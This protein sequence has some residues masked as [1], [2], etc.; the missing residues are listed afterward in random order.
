MGS[1]TIS[2]PTRLTACSISDDVI[3]PSFFDSSS[4]TLSKKKNLITLRMKGWQLETFKESYSH[5]MNSGISLFKKVMMER[6]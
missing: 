3:S 5:K 4:A 2:T 1:V 6:K